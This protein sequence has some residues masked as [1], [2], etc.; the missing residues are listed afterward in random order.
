MTLLCKCYR[1]Q[2]RV[3]LKEFISVRDDCTAS[4]FAGTAEFPV[5]LKLP[6]ALKVIQVDSTNVIKC[7][8]VVFTIFSANYTFVLLSASN[9]LWLQCQHFHGS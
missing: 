8:H 9:A 1:K 6:R 7:R 3:L 4:K 2:F 5:I